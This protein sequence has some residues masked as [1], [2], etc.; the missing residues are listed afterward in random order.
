MD[1]GELAPQLSI[2]TVLRGDGLVEMIDTEREH[3]D[4]WFHLILPR[5]TG[6]DIMAHA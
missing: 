6:S 5:M 3:G 2:N 1:A 4:A